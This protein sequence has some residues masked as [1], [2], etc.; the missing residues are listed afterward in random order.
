MLPRRARTLLS[1]LFFRS[2][3]ELPRSCYSCPYNPYFMLCNVRLLWDNIVCVFCEA[4]VGDQAL[5]NA[6]HKTASLYRINFCF[7]EKIISLLRLAMPELCC[8]SP[9]LS[10]GVAPPP[11]CTRQGYAIWYIQEGVSRLLS[12]VRR[13]LHLFATNAASPPC[14][15][16]YTHL[17]VQFPSVWTEV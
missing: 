7:E 9:S 17:V 11:P 10:K 13:T 6:M 8:A 4:K 3:E 2:S 15:A 5:G 1:P 16:S 12:S 14:S